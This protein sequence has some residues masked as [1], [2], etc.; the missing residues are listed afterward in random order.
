MRWSAKAERGS[1]WLITLIVWLARRAGR[2]LCRALLYPI[3]LYFVVT[4][5]MARTGSL[6]FLSAVYGRPA[7]LREVFAHIYSFAATLLD[8]VYMAAGDFDRFEVTIEGVALLDRALQDGR[9]CVLLGSHLG[10]F[11]LMM[12]ANRAMDGRP[13]SVLMHVDPRARLRR[14]AGID[15]GTLTVIPLGRP[16]SY[17]RAHEILTGGGI[18][19][20]LADRVDGAGASL[21]TPFL[22]RPVGLPVAPHVLAARSRAAVL[23]CFGV[24]E[25][26][27]RYRIE[28]LEFGDPAAQ[29]SRGASLQPVVDRYAGKL[30]H[31]ARR[32]PLNWFNF[33]PYWSAGERA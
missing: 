24:Y 33:Y 16:D 12:L 9:G 25:G 21:A 30:E 28:F 32:Y 11:D 31:Y 20:I 18:V 3:V 22:G 13:V 6:E 8:R 10:S 26:G 2:P 23:M 1:A 7:R 19:G 15:E 17:L 5:R 27:N 4:D 29:G 14:I